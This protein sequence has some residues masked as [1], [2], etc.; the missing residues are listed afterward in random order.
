MLA[1]SGAAAWLGPQ[2]ARIV[3]NQAS[4]Q[5][6]ME[7]MEHNLINYAA[8]TL[9]QLPNFLV[10][11]ETLAFMNGMNI[12]VAP[13]GG[14]TTFTPGPVR[15]ASVSSQDVTFRDGHEVAEEASKRRKGEP[16]VVVQAT[17]RE[18][19][20][21]QTMVVS[22]A[23][24]GKISWSRWEQGTDGIEGVIH[25]QVPIDKSHY[26][27]QYCCEYYSHEFKS[28]PFRETVAYHGEIA[29]DAK[30]GVVM[31][32]TTEAELAP[33]KMVAE[34]AMAV[35][36]RA[37]DIGGRQTVLPVRGVSFLRIYTREPQ[38]V[39]HVPVYSGEV[40][41]NLDDTE[42]KNYR[43]FRGE[44]RILTGDGG[45]GGGSPDRP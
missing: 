32:A 28:P 34:A 24:H 33:G 7:E 12:E 20:P 37:V 14:V 10:A 2:P 18:F 15:L 43:Q 42:F 16:Q 30:T 9:R 13:F 31:R 27:V 3:A 25:Y 17:A 41:T 44:M 40:T 22:D 19:G 8:T 4:D 5:A 1:L 36:Y 39:D 23:I 26:V 21:F 6:A 45:T 38:V 29:F 11:R 35:E